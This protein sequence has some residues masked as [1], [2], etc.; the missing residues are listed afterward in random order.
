MS[1]VS[2]LNAWFFY[3]TP[4]EFGLSAFSDVFWSPYY[5]M[6]NLSIK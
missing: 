4:P 3:F 2:N 5:E 6:Y 1:V